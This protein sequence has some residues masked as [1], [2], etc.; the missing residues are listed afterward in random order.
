M[1]TNP[2]RLILIGAGGHAAVV[3]ESA[4]RAGH[5]IVAIASAGAAP[6][7]T[8]FDGTVFDGTVRLGDPDSAAGERAIE[9]EVRRG[10]R[11]MLAVGDPGSR[12]RWAARFHG[13]FSSAIVDPHAIVSPS[14]TLA[15]GSF[16]GAGAIVQSRAQ[17]GAHAIVNTRA[18]IEHDCQ[19]A[20][21][22]HVSPG[23]ILC[24]NVTVGAR[25]QVGAGAVVI[26]GRLIGEGAVVGAGAVVV[27]DVPAE[28]TVRGVPA[29]A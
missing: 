15:D 2:L 16:I 10:A 9:D 24:G 25:A 23:A 11:I 13:C 28:L 3:A 19:L 27:R 26:P 20:A 17:I 18:V 14:A 5:T 8:V 4:R 7:G 21:C 6:D 1:T 12:S 29:R 22:T